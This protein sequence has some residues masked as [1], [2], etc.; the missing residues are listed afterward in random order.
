MI[1]LKLTEEQL[2]GLHYAVNEARKGSV[3]IK[4]NKA[5]LSALLI[6]HGQVLAMGKERTFDYTTPEATK[7][8]DA[9]E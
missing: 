2:N 8:K 5:A 7:E 4:V 6:D 9:F 1:K 3:K